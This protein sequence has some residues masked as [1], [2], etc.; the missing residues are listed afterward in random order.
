MD[1]WKAKLPSRRGR[2]FGR[3]WRYVRRYRQ[4]RRERAELRRLDDR[5]L[6]DIG[7]TRIDALRES[8]RACARKQ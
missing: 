1:I 2:I 8:R 5:A 7:I 6:R 4:C 3:L